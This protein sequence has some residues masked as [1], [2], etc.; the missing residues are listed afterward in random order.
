MITFLIFGFYLVFVGETRKNV[1]KGALQEAWRRVV[2][3]AAHV[4][5]LRESLNKPYLLERL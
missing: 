4:A 1:E 5:T 2:Q 3:K